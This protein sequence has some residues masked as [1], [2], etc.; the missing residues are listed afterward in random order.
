[1]QISA[2]PVR[3]AMRPAMAQCQR[4]RR[5]WGGAVAR[6]VTGL[7]SGQA[8]GLVSRRDGV[9]GV[10]PRSGNPDPDSSLVDSD[11]LPSHVMHEPGAFVLGGM[12]CPGES[13][14]AEHAWRGFPLTMASVDGSK[15]ARLLSLGGKAPADCTSHPR[16]QR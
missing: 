7:R 11:G 12:R 8:G 1:M 13:A 15:I 3:D 6:G 10:G 16:W 5:V 14:A 2:R 4:R 9:K